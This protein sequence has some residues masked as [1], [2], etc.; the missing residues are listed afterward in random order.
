M[1]AHV[2]PYV[3]L[4]I[5]PSASRAEAARAYRRLA[6]QFHPDVNPGPAAA[7][8]MRRINEAWEEISEGRATASAAA[9]A[10]APPTWTSWPG[11]R[12]SEPRHVRRPSRPEPV[13]ASFGDRRAVVLAVWF[14]LVSLGFIGTWLG[15]LA[16]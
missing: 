13:E 9:A 2:N 10:A 15:G 4:G 1:A 5:P 11:Y 16:R 14:V 8:R 12:Y 6:K 7:E 3:A